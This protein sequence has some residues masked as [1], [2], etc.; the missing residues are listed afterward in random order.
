LGQVCVKEE[1]GTKKDKGEY[2]DLS[3]NNFFQFFCCNNVKIHPKK[4]L[5]SYYQN[6]V[7]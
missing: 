2:K 7:K 4:T 1:K 5:L 6:I 3:K